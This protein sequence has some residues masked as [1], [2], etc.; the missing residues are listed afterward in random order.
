MALNNLESIGFQ[1]NKHPIAQSFFIDNS[2]GIFLTKVGLFFKDAPSG[3]D[4]QHPMTL[5]IRPI[6]DSGVPSASSVIPSSTVVRNASN[7]YS[8]ISTDASSES[9]FTFDSPVFLKGGKSYAIVLLT[10][11]AVYK[12][13]V[14]ET[15]EF[16]LGTTEERISKNPVSGTLFKSS[17][18]ITFN[19]VQNTDLAFK[20]YKAK[21]KYSSAEVV[22]NNSP[23][24][25]VNL[26]TNSIATDSD[27]SIIKITS[28]MHGFQ[29]GDQ[30]T[31]SNVSGIIGGIN[32]AD[33][34]GTRPIVSRDF[35]TIS[36]RAGSLTGPDVNGVFSI[37]SAKTALFSE[38]GGTDSA[39]ISKNIVYDRF[40]PSIKNLQ[41][42]NTNVFGSFKGTQAES[43]SG[44]GTQYARET[45]FTNVDLN[46]TNSLA[47]KSFLIANSEREGVELNANDK[48]LNVKATILTLNKND[49]S[50]VIDLERCSFTAI[51]TVIDNQDPTW[52][53]QDSADA[54]A[55]SSNSLTNSAIS[56]RP[57]T[58]P[59]GGSSAAKWIS[60]VVT[61]D[62]RSKG[63]KI[64][65]SANRPPDSHIDMY[66]R[67]CGADEN[68]KTRSFVR[69]DPE[70]PIPTD[71]NERVF[72]EYRYLPGGALGTL[73]DFTQMQFKIVMRSSYMHKSPTI[74]DFRA[75]S[76]V[77]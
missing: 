46:T 42:L 63:I 26:N 69:I 15:Y 4:V 51:G 39:T 58:L 61:I 62:E 75:I 57:E 72:R 24:P 16:K 19:P 37:D 28:W 45:S 47:T 49:V 73:D 31:I 54:G 25:P 9:I 10:N 43:F 13:F 48:S 27:S 76:L 59:S 41:P 20:L 32:A 50:P 7:I 71:E 12:V 38:F 6:T 22:F 1:H 65:L 18:S 17:N 56:F 55:A 33:I 52:I 67:T 11:S 64:L 44:L 30:V 53:T 5:Q 35:S 8:E 21:F 77:V 29:S 66:F 23:L 14:G 70:E 40:V 34:N 68:I 36:V 3:A 2:E 74:K 60:K